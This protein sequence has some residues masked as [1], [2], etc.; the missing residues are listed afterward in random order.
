MVLV[1]VFLE[2]VLVIVIVVFFVVIAIIVLVVTATVALTLFLIKGWCC[3][4]DYNFHL[5]GRSEKA[6]RTPVSYIRNNIN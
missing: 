3:E 4:L 6:I 1:I 5:M 2:L